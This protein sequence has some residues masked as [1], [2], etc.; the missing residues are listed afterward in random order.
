MTESTAPAGKSDTN[1]VFNAD[2][3][4]EFNFTKKQLV[5]YETGKDLMDWILE[6]PMR[7]L[8][9]GSA[10]SAHTFKVGKE[11]K[12]FKYYNN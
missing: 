10:Y 1:T 5:E 6:N 12:T 3:K 2:I 8:V 4:A 9:E 11:I 7:A